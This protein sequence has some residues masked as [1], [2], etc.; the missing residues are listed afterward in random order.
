MF[1]VKYTQLLPV[2][3]GRNVTD[4]VPALA[5]SFQTPVWPPW[6]STSTYGANDDV[7]VMRTGTSFVALKPYTAEYVLPPRHAVPLDDVSCPDTVPFNPTVPEEWQVVLLEPQD[8][9]NV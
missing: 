6:G 1:D 7:K 2:A 5:L 9:V 8:T 3:A 4:T